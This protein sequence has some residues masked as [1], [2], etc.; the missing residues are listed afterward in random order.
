M[1][2]SPFLDFGFDFNNAQESLNVV[3]QN[4]SLFFQL[5]NPAH[6]LNRI[7][8][9]INQN[10]DNNNFGAGLKLNSFA[11]FLDTIHRIIYA[12]LLFQLVTAF[13]K[14]SK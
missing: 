7:I 14:F 9:S 13:R 6:D 3:I 4:L 5:F 2:L 11:Y 10:L 8:P 1:S 12:F